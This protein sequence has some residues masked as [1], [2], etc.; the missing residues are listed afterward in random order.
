MPTVQAYFGA[1]DDAC[2]P[3]FP[4]PPYAQNG[5]TVIIRSIAT[6]RVDG[7]YSLIIGAKTLSGD[8][9]AIPCAPLRRL[10]PTCVP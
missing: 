10:N 4:I 6:D 2:R 3:L 1:N 9:Q 8:F 7:S 5:S